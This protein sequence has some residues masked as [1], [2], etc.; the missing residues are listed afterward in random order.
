MLAFLS[1]AMCE[2]DG[3][4]RPL[5]SDQAVVTGILKELKIYGPERVNGYVDPIKFWLDATSRFPLPLL[6]K[7]ALN[8]LPILD[9]SVPCERAFSRTGL[10]VNDLHSQL[11]PA[12]VNF[13]VFLQNNPDL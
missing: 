4:D 5:T 3:S 1:S 6:S 12:K 10:I 11:N 7:M 2:Y 13:L 9:T 8:L